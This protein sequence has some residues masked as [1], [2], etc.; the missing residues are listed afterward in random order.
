MIAWSL[1]TVAYAGTWLL[2]E[3]L[4]AEVRP[5]VPVGWVD[6]R[7]VGRWRVDWTPGEPTWTA[8]LCAIEIDPVLG[9][10]MSWP[11]A[12]RDAVPPLTR[13]VSFD[14]R[15]FEAGPVV[16]TLGAADDDRDGHPGVT[17]RV[18]HPRAGAGEVYV[19][20]TAALAWSGEL[21]ADGRIVGTVAYK[22]TQQ[23]L[24]AS[25]WWLRIAIAQREAADRP[26]T[27]TLAPW[28]DGAG[29]PAP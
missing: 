12:L 8:R 21:A 7:T 6:V 25:R 29:C 19:R 5:P 22:P 15:R 13:P 10:A 4:V 28:P 27:F 1:A 9:A 11:D 26:S 2:E 18:R 14:G 17:V 20:Q 16:E 24:G 3:Q 23:L